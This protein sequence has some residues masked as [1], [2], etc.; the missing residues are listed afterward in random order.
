MGQKKLITTTS[1]W[2]FPEQSEARLNAIEREIGNVRT[3]I[4]ERISQASTS[5]QDHCD[6]KFEQVF[7]MLRSLQTL[8]DEFGAIGNS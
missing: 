5:L 6:A 8:D 3:L 2:H 1:F 4:Q 7:Q